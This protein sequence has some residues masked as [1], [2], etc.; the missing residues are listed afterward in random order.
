MSK[1]TIYWLAIQWTIIACILASCQRT[2]KKV[3]NALD[4]SQVVSKTISPKVSAI[5]IKIDHV[6]LAV[7]NLTST[8]QYYSEKLGFTLKPGTLHENSIL[9][10]FAKFSDGTLIE[11]ISASEAKDELAEW[12]LNFVKQN[13]N[14]SAFAAFK[15]DSLAMMDSL[16][17]CL[18]DNNLSYSYQKGGYTH[19][20][21]VNH[22]E[23]FHTP[24]FIHYTQAVNDQAEFLYHLNGAN[25]LIAIWLPYRVMDMELMD[26]LG[27]QSNDSIQIPTFNLPAANVKLAEGA[28][29]MLPDSSEQRVIGVSLAVNDISKTQQF[30]QTSLEKEIAI[31]SWKY[32]R[33]IFISPEETLGIWIEFR[34]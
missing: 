23:R 21:S 20:L 34:E 33:S 28:I 9:N 11:L 6:N 5:P 26:V 22:Y 14:G 25:R 29:Y 18:D 24:F 1:T 15:M 16:K 10:A 7:A 31:Q 8:K 2:D 13:S 12:Y 17:I 30:L 4:S 27:W 32:G 19:L 3:E